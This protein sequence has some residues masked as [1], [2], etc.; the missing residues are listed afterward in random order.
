MGL[1]LHPPPSD[2]KMMSLLLNSITSLLR[3]LPAI[4]QSP[5]PPRLRSYLMYGPLGCLWVT[6]D[7]LVKREDE[8]RLSG[9]I[10]LSGFYILAHIVKCL[11]FG[12]LCTCQP[13]SASNN[14]TLDKTTRIYKLRQ[15]TL[16]WITVKRM[17]YPLYQAYLVYTPHSCI[18][19][20][21]RLLQ[22]AFHTTVKRTDSL[23]I[24]AD[25][26]K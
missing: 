1:F 10:Y 18:I 8:V 17:L 21:L 20:N 16:A 11:N 5:P 15:L 13:V 6:Y 24:C 3:I 4:H 7:L 12:E 2:C 9:P 19:P 23:V 26:H 25:Q 22:C 14:K